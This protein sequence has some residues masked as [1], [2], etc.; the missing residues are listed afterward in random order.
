MESRRLSLMV[1][2]FVILTLG[3][4]AAIL[5]SFSAERGFLTSRYRL[6]AYFQ[7]VQ[8]L[9][10][11]AP[12]RLAGK[13]VG[14]VEHV[15]F[16]PLEE[17]LPPIRVILQV[18]EAVSDRIRTDSVA[19]IGTIGLL[20]D[21]YVEIT[22][23]TDFGRV[24]GEG[25]E[26]ATV[27]PIDLNLAVERGTEAI[28]NIARLAGSVNSVVDEFAE[29][30]G[31]R[32]LAESIADVSQI[33]EE[34]QTGDGLLH[35]LI[36]DRY[37]GGGVESIERSLATLEGILAEVARG[38]GLL[39]TLI[40]EPVGEPNPITEVAQAADN[41]NSILEKLDRGEGTLGRLLTDPTLYEDVKVLI[42][43]AQ[44]SFVVRSLVRMAADGEE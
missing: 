44:R 2:A 34:I 11:G 22:M 36:Y 41:M 1:G 9:T 14:S 4:A 39:H 31:G 3:V 28:D 42:G 32:G 35:S 6:V 37:A 19:S 20:G 33:V 15:T 12:V 5:F 38:D 40:Y 30:M 26:V 10:S 7:N 8:G 25:D 29:R 16:A 27:S 24:L 18:D 23:G 17:D 43:G 13:D 21:K